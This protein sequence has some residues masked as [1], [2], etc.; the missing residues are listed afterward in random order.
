MTARVIFVHPAIQ[1]YR[2]ELFRHLQDDLGVHFLFV[3]W[4]E[5][6]RRLLPQAGLTR[7][8]VLP[9][10]GVFPYREGVS[11]K[12]MSEAATASYDIWISS[13]LHWFPTHAAFPVVKARRK[14]FVLWT[15]DWWWPGGWVGRMGRPYV[16]AIMRGTDRF[17]VAGGR[18]RDF[19]VSNGVHP[20]R[21]TVAINAT[22]DLARRP[23][24]ASFAALQERHR[25]RGTSF[26]FLYLNRIV[27]YKGLDHL[28]A[29]FRTVTTQVPGTRLIVCGDGATRRVSE[30]LSRALGLTNVDFVGTVPGEEVADY[31][32]LA[33]AYVHPA[34]FADGRVRAE[35]WGFTVNEALSMGKPVIATDAVAAAYDLVENGTTGFVVRAGDVDAL[36][37]RMTELA[38]D[39]DRARRM[40][41]A[42]RL[43]MQGVTPYHQYL[44]FKATIDSLPRS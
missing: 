32:R 31:Y 35:A 40:G 30:Q 14:Q 44:G 2:A 29:A 13:I 39:P 1:P 16:R 11:G 22:A 28:L 41:E 26:T 7:C 4:Q 33:D 27:P 12:L 21:V 20:D 19:L 23:P 15:E 9:D 34:Q 3:G 18:T 36:A 24:G 42:G 6:N 17:I 43:R 5:H 38:R 8:D 37:S 10:R 25:P